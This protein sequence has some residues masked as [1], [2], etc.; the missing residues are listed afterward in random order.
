MPQPMSS[1]HT[2]ADAGWCEP[3][4]RCPGACSSGFKQ[5]S[6]SSLRSSLLCIGRNHR[7]LLQ[8]GKAHKTISSSALSDRGVCKCNASSPSAKNF[9]KVSSQPLVVR[10]GMNAVF[11]VHLNGRAVCVQHLPVHDQEAGHCSSTNTKGQAMSG[12][13]SLFAR[14]HARLQYLPA[15]VNEKL[16]TSVTKISGAL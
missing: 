6:S 4:S 11:F 3:T 16:M 1:I 10:P 2:A 15:M 9:L 8:A 7:S 13:P 14:P 12:S 5:L